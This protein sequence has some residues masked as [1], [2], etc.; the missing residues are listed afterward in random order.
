MTGTMCLA[1]RRRASKSALYVQLFKELI[2]LLRQLKEQQEAAGSSD[3]LN[4][5][6][7]A[8]LDGSDGAR[9]SA[10]NVVTLE[11]SAAHLLVFALD[12]LMNVPCQTLSDCIVIGPG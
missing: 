1:S 10:D 8:A 9:P 4:D 5:D 11:C 2:R 3:D 7:D 6:S 12:A